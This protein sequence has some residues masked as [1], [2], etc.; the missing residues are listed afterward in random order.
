MM[1]SNYALMI[2]LGHLS[3]PPALALSLSLSFFLLTPPKLRLILKTFGDEMQL[4]SSNCH[5][6]LMRAFS[7]GIFDVTCPC[8]GVAIGAYWL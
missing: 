4:K 6:N 2:S 1:S 3:L 5:T 8:P 7:L